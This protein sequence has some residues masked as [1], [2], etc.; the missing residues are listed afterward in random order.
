MF[1]STVDVEELRTIKEIVFHLY[2]DEKIV[3]IIFNPKE[4]E[5]AT[6]QT[7]IGPNI[8]LFDLNSS[9]MAPPHG[10]LNIYTFINRSA[11][12]LSNIVSIE[13]YQSGVNSTSSEIFEI[14]TS[15][16]DYIRIDHLSAPDVVLTI[17]QPYVQFGGQL[18]LRYQQRMTGMLKELHYGS[19]VKIFPPGAEDAFRNNTLGVFPN[20]PV[21]FIYPPATSILCA[22]IGKPLPNISVFKVNSDGNEESLSTEAIVAGKYM[23]MKIITLSTEQTKETINGLYICRYTFS[24][25]QMK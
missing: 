18:T 14:F 25:S 23:S 17:R 8:R 2:N 7:I 21:T 9:Y 15:N 1:T 4:L 20:D 3:S 22:A 16:S 12:E 10:D 19:S 11:A 5:N 6:Q 24:M 13:G